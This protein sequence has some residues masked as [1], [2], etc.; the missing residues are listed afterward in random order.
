MNQGYRVMSDVAVSPPAGGSTDASGATAGSTGTAVAPTDGPVATPEPMPSP[1][2]VNISIERAKSAL[3]VV[4]AADGSIWFVPGFVF[5]DATGYVGNVLSVV[6]GVIKL[7]EP[8]AID[9]GF[10]VR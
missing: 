6:E 10:T 8:M 2:I 4:Y 1:K 3:M 7:P 5:Y 9:S